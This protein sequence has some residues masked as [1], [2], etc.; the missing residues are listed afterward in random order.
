VLL[1]KILCGNGPAKNT[2]T[3]AEVFL[4]SVKQHGFLSKFVFR[5][6]LYLIAIT[7]GSLNHIW[8]RAMGIF[9]NICMN[10]FIK[11]TNLAKM[12]LPDAF[13]KGNL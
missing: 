6:R 9:K 13:Q 1:S 5:A 8:R 2:P 4:Y 3:L 7:D 11:I 12:Y 10:V